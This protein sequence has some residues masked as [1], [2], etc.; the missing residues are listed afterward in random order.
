MLC[1]TCAL[2]CP[3]AQDPFWLEQQQANE[4]IVSDAA[5]EGNPIPPDR[6]HRNR[7][8]LGWPKVLS[9]FEFPGSDSAAGAAADAARL[10]ELAAEV[11]DPGRLMAQ[12]KLRIKIAEL[13]RLRSRLRPSR[14]HQTVLATMATSTDA[15]SHRV[16]GG[17]L[18]KIEA[19]SNAAAAICRGDTQQVNHFLS[20]SGLSL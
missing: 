12:R 17:V 2:T 13:R 14:I 4:K 6:D 10:R 1:V 3:F 11:A 18:G 8:A 5:A 7:P 15:S 20:L 9:K 19:L 16:Y